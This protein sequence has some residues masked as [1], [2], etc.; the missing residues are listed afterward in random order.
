M[1]IPL[2]RFTAE[3]VA[4]VN[5]ALD[6]VDAGEVI[7][8]AALLTDD[9]LTEVLDPQPVVHVRPFAN[10]REAGECLYALLEPY[11]TWISAIE[12]DRGLWTWLA[13]A[14]VDILAPA[15]ADGTRRLKDR[16]RWVAAV[17][18]YRKYYRHLLAGPYRIYRAHKDDP[19][20]A[21]AVLATVVERPGEVVEQFASRQELIINPNLMTA[22]TTLYYDGST[23]S[24][25][26]GA[27]GKAGGSARRL[28]DVLQQF[29]VTW[30]I[31]G[32]PPYEILD[33]LPTEFDRFVPA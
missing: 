19:G 23:G 27:G 21:M 22:I 2:R 30:D 3:G 26:P 14:W 8:L 4:T 29:D 28:A 5:D 1:R 24:L 31:Y 9:R 17:D 12:R 20:R 15:A 13:L 18:D 7:D 16:A 11:E 33:L 25:K 6:R 32:M 10:R